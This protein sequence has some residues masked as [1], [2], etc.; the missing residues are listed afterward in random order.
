[1]RVATKSSASGFEYE[2]CSSIDSTAVAFFLQAEPILV[3]GMKT[4]KPALR[5]A[6]SYRLVI[7]EI[8]GSEIITSYTRWVDAV[9]VRGS[10]VSGSLSNIQPAI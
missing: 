10:G 9:Q 2:S 3:G 7:E 6:T 4:F 5:L 8:K 1:V